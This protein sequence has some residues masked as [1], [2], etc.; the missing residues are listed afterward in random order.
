MDPM[1]LSC[2]P[3]R[4]KCILLVANGGD[5]RPFK[6]LAA[7]SWHDQ[8][9]SI[10]CGKS[11]VPP[12]NGLTCTC[13]KPDIGRGRR[14]GGDKRKTEVAPCRPILRTW[15]CCTPARHGASSRAR[16]WLE[17]DDDGADHVGQHGRGRPA[18]AASSDS[19]RLLVS[20]NS[21][22]SQVQGAGW[23]LREPSGRGGR[24]ACR[25]LTAWTTGLPSDG[26]KVVLSIYVRGR[27]WPRADD[28]GL[29]GVFA[30]A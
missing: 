2:K 25:R 8:G 24:L 23:Q 14:D 12:R 3:N 29:A 5:A 9:F 15:C 26:G 1:A 28:R 18:S 16:P 30:V 19:R 22:C 13:D 6:H 20:F 7:H 21:D 17:G 10:R 11:V 27:W 4:T